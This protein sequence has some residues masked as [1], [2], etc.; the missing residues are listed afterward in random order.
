LEEKD[1]A[2]LRVTE[3]CLSC[4]S[5]VEVCDVFVMD[6][7]TGHAKE[8]DSNS[9]APCVKEAMDICPVNAIVWD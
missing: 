8:K 1:M 7:T 6:D 3:E 9:T 5:C 2:E 4:E